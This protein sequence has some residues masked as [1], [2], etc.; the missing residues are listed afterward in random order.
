[1]KKISKAIFIVLYFV[2]IGC[3]LAPQPFTMAMYQQIQPGQEIWEV[4]NIMK[5]Q[6][7]PIAVTATPGF[8]CQGLM[9]Q[10]PNGSNIQVLFMNGKVYTIAQAGLR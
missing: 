1:M 3:D 5:K 8:V 2:L 10:N 7:I 6:G 9:W 4:E